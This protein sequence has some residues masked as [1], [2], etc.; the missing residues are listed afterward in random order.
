MDLTGFCLCLDYA[1][2]RSRFQILFQIGPLSISML[3]EPSPRLTLEISYKS[4]RFILASSGF[5]FP[6]S[7]YFFFVLMSEPCADPAP[8]ATPEYICSRR[9]YWLSNNYF[10]RSS[11][12][13]LRILLS[14]SERS[15]QRFMYDLFALASFSARSSFSRTWAA[16]V[17]F[18]I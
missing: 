7:S 9:N 13:L 18:K 17:S 5:I 3:V 14:S 10:L 1:R 6:P 15:I 2:P 11:S 8:M 16:S 12:F 4:M